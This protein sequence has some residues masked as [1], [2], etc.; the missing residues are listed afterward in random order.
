MQAVV[1]LQRPA[2]AIA[3]K[4]HEVY[5]QAA[6]PDRWVNEIKVDPFASQ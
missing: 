5:K 2:L 4:A 1:Y 6:S 3:Q